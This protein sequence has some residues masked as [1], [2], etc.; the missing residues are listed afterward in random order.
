MITIKDLSFK[1]P[2]SDLVL[3]G[4]NLDIKKGD[5]VGIIGP[6]GAG[7][8]TL[9]LHLNATLIG[10]TGEIT[11]DGI[12]INRHNL[13]TIRQKVGMVFQNPDDQLFMATV[14]DDIAFGLLN[15][16][17]E[18]LQI[19]ER[20]TSI[21]AHFGLSGFEGKSPH[22]LS[23]GEK[24]KIALAGILVMNPEIL[25]LDEPTISLDPRARREFIELIH[26]IPGTKIIAGHDL[27][28]I[29]KLTQRTVI[30]NKGKIIAHG[31]TQEIIQN[32]QLLFA[33]RLI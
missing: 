6:N 31:P 10:K 25:V 23:L 2:D 29:Q 17:I 8:S 3:E 33:N 7:K 16:G 24:K 28:M 1:Y 14:F 11:I 13:K 20:I 18:E 22:H 9:L 26:N 12:S 5:S 32:Q 30:M 15:V 27:D 4:I 21:L 19:K